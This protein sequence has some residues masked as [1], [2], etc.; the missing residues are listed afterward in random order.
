MELAV[1]SE[2][3]RASHRNVVLAFL[4]L[5]YAFNTIDR[6]IIAILQEPI[7]ADFG[8]EDW[9]LGLLS[10]SAFAL[11]YT[12][13]GLPIARYTDRGGNRVTIISTALG[14]WSLLTAACGLAQNYVQLLLFRMG[15]GVGEAG[16]IPPSQ[17][18]IADYFA[19]RERG[20]AMGIYTSGIAIGAL[21]GIMGGS[22]L[23]QAFGWRNALIMV[24]LPGIAVALL[25]KLIAREPPRG[26]A[27]GGRLEADLTIPTGQALRILMANRTYRQI[28]AGGSLCAVA[29]IGFSFWVP[30]FLIRNHGLSLAQVG[31]WWGLIFGFSGLVGAMLGGYLCDRLGRKDPKGILLIPVATM[32][33]AIPFQIA[34]IVAGDP[35]LALVLFL[36]P[37]IAY[38]IWIVPMFTLSQG[39]VPV[40]VRATSSAVL[41][42][43][44]NMVGLGFG[45]LLI[46]II[47]DYSGYLAGD[48]ATGL[49]WA[50]LVLTAS[51]IWAALH[52]FLGMRTI[53]GDLV[54]R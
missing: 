49:R 2:G 6:Q 14:L 51:N 38:S 16:C 13:I 50:L 17:S 54:S 5:I 4:V 42:F 23:A 18:L 36:V 1:P 39:L 48:A 7:R 43:I 22:W 24:G 44:V 19:P 21:A 31:T 40:G 11:F 53:A 8:L 41:S 28:A 52:F 30:S 47:S 25:F 32:L 46:G 10:G 12:I 37:T 26:M 20:R 35:V 45:P 33:L 29:T 15:V 27:D 9:Q 34:G 3:R